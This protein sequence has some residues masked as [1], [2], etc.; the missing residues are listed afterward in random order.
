MK[1]DV[2]GCSTCQPG[3][4]QWEEFRLFSKLYIQYDYRTLDGKLFSCIAP[5]LDAARTKRDMW[6]TK[7]PPTPPEELN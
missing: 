7:H 6:L 5:S 2:N 3:Q 1:T 4:E